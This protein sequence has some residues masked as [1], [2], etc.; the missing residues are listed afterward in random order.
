[1]NNNNNANNLNVQ[2]LPSQ[3]GEHALA[4]DNF[5]FSK[6]GKGRNP[7]TLY[8]ICASNKTT[9]CS[10][11][12]VT[13]GQ[14]LIDIRGQHQHHNDDREITNREMKVNIGYTYINSVMN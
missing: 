12:A 7:N 13:E 1:M 4:V 10:V 8:W 2:W 11:R 6:N 9:G 3:K 5:I 14:N